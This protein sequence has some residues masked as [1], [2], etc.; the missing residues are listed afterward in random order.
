[1]S[2]KVNFV[3]KRMDDID[4]LKTF[5]DK[6][7]EFILFG[8][9]RNFDLFRKCLDGKIKISYCVDNNS[10][11]QGTQIDGYEIKSPEE[12]I[13]KNNKQKIL[14]LTG[15][16][17][18]VR[19]Q[20]DHIGFSEG[21]DYC[22]VMEFI[23]MYYWF[24][25]KKIYLTNISFIVTP[26]C[27]LNCKHCSILISKSHSKKH[28]DLKALKRDIEV[29]FKNVDFVYNFKIMGGE[30][31]M[32]P[33]FTEILEYI[34][35]EY[36]NRIENLRVVTNGTIKLDDRTLKIIKGNNIQMEINDYSEF[37]DYKYSISDY[38]EELE[39]R[40]ISYISYRT[41]TDDQWVD[42]GDF[43]VEKFKKGLVTHNHFKKC[44]YYSRGLWGSKL[45]YCT[46]NAAAVNMGGMPVDES[47]FLDLE[48]VIEPQEFIE[49]ELGVLRKG[50]T[51]LCSNCNG[52]YDV[53]KILIPAGEQMSVR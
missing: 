53:N 39:R 7:V 30:P 19:K 51:S 13:H 48:N 12:L 38:I 23:P 47:D 43:N 44:A 24:V 4:K 36:R 17:N 50:A 22:Y 46:I 29:L 33:H 32:S 14:I 18:S 34:S 28:R 35:E 1:M 40:E 20:L 2:Y 45:Y 16:I 37:V 5:L 49:F 25:E 10:K 41:T 8:V 26:N 9:G 27:T 31:T 52:D 6:D 42:F 15:S 21:D 11:L 3:S